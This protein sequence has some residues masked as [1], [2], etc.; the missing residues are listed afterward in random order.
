MNSKYLP[1]GSVVLLKNAKK[2]VEIWLFNINNVIT[3]YFSDELKQSVIRF[4][5]DR[6]LKFN[7]S[8][9]TE[10]D[11]FEKNIC[12]WWKNR[13][14]GDFSKII[15]FNVSKIKNETIFS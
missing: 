10:N 3:A 6:C 2:R 12:R 15:T 14:Y 4:N 8:I 5:N 13:E 1:I 11:D 7:V 9:L